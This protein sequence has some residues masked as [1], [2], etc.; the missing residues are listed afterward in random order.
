MIT[1]WHLSLTLSSSSLQFLETFSVRIFG[2]QVIYL[3]K[4]SVGRL[5]ADGTC[6]Y[7]WILLYVYNIHIQIKICNVK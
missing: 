5:L 3:D 1:S 2:V 6:D 4:L 7:M